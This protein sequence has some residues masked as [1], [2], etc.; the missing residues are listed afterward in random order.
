MLVG[1]YRPAPASEVPCSPSGKCPSGQTCNTNHQPPICNGPDSPDAA[2]VLDLCGD[3][4]G[5]QAGAP[6]PSIHGCPSNAGRSALRGPAAA[7]TLHAPFGTN[8]AQRGAAVGAGNQI[9]VQENSAGDV[10]DFDGASG[11]PG[12]SFLDADGS[13]LEPVP[14]IDNQNLVYLTTNYGKLY[15]AS[16]QTG[17]FQWDLQ[18]AGAFSAPQM[19]APGI[20]YYGSQ[21]PYGFYAVDVVARKQAWHFDVPDAG[22]ATTAPALANGLVYFVDTKNSRLFALDASSGA[23]VIDV[24]VAGG[25]VGSPVIGV[26]FVYVATRM[27]GIAAFDATT[28]AAR[29]QAPTNTNVVQPA[30]LASGAVVASSTDGNAFVLD[31]ATG[32]TEHL[33]ALGGTVNAPPIVD[34]AD[35]VYFATSAGT[36]AVSQALAPVWTSPLTGRIA[37]GDRE[38]IVL[39]SA[40]TLAII[41]D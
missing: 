9:I 24:P 8:M 36:V 4:S 38:V 30:L 35:T 2:V 39:P 19:G 41:G 17:A 23:P 33:A 7:I 22:D 12:W 10:L 14:L 27:N 3:A 26:E 31:R 11:S 37:L 32:A 25:A 15:V 5:L 16:A 18:L 21:N 34:A 13:G 29:W 6:W 40:N 20:L 1:C 28:G